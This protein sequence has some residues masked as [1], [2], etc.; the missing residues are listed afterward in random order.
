M[1]TRTRSRAPRHRRPS[2]THPRPRAVRV[3]T[4]PRFARRRRAV[5]R[6]KQRRLILRISIVVALFGS[7][8]AAF[9]SPLLR[10]RA[11]DVVGAEHTAARDVVEAAELST[12]NNLL[13]LS[14]DGVADRVAE[15][16]WVQS[17]E[18]DRMLPGTVRIRIEERRPAL[19]VSLGAA[20]WTIDGGGRVLES[21]EVRPGLPVL[22][23]I[24]AGTVAPGVDLKTT[25]ARGALRVWSTLPDAIR[26]DVEAIFAP[27]LERITLV[28]AD[29]TQVRF[30]A[31]EEAAAKNEVLR[32]LRAQLAAEGDLANYIDV[33]VPS[34]PA[35]SQT[36]PTDP[37]ATGGEPTPAATPPSP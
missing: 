1:S 23:G 21:G 32:A 37:S 19:I 22:A 10:V 6:A 13:L 36:A 27:T 25:E 11:V 8:W 26:K 16:P 29:G 15:L 5:A 33:R 30:G 9:F 28:L 7:L 18:V 35:V 34:R 4:D 2:H 12:A 31:P 24:Q 20:R 14:G 3:A 17:V